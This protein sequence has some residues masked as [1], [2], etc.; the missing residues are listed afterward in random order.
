MKKLLNYFK[1]FSD[2]HPQSFVYSQSD[3]F[4]NKARKSIRNSSTVGRPAYHQP[5]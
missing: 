4:D 3:R 2:P 5:L 1:N